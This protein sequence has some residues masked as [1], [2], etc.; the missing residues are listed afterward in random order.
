MPAI[1]V[2]KTDTFEILRQ[3]VNE[4]GSGLFN[5]SAGGSDLSAGNIKLGDG[6]RTAPSLSFTSDNSL[7]IYKPSNNTF[8]FVSGAKKVADFSNTGIYSFKDL[9]IRQTTLNTAGISVLNDGTN[10]DAGSYADIPLVGGTG[11]GATASIVVTEFDGNIIDPGSNYV[12]GSYSDIPLVGG[13]GSG[14]TASF[15]VEG[16]EGFISNTGTGYVPGTYLNVP[17]TGGSGSG[18]IADIIITGQTNLLGTITN[19]GSGYTEGVYTSVQVLNKPIQTFVVTTTS[20]PGTPPPNNVYVIDGVTQKQLTL[21]KG[22]TYRFDI[23]DSS[24]TGH[25]LIFQTSLGSFLS[26]SNYAAVTKGIAGQP[27][28]FVDLIIKPSAA[29]ETI[30][31]NCQVHDGMG[32]NISITTGT[33]GFYG[34]NASATITVNS[35]GNISDVEITSA[36]SGYKQNDIIQVYNINIGGTGSGFEFTLSAPSYTGEVTSVQIQGNGNNYVKNDVL[37]SS[38]SNLGGSGS[39]FAFTIDNDPNIVSDLSFTSKGSGYQIEDVLELPKT[40]SNVQTQLKSQ[41]SNL[42]TTLSTSSAVV[43]VSSTTGILPGMLVSQNIQGDVGL[44]SVGTT[45]LSVDSSTQLTLSANPTTSGS[46]TL[47]FTS[48]GVLTEISV[49][50]VQGIFVGSLVSKTAGTGILSSNTTVS[51]INSV[52]NTITLSQQPQ[53]AGTATLSFVPPFGDPPNDFQYEIT[54]LGQIESFTIESGGNGYSL[55]DTLSVNASDLTQPISYSV[56]NKEVIEITFVGTVSSTTFSVGD[57]LKKKDGEVISTTQVSAP[58]VSQTVISN[59][60]TT[61]SNSSPVITV[62][63]TTGI[64]AGM[65]VSQNFQTDTGVLSGGTTVLS[66]DSSTQLTLSVTPFTSGSATLTFSSDETGTYTNVSSTTSGN[67]SGATFDVE[68]N[69]SGNIT[70]ITVNSPGYFYTVGDI[71]TISGTSVGGVSPDNDIELEVSIVSTYQNLEIYSIQTSSGNISSILLDFDNINSGDLLIEPLLI[72]TEY[73]INTVSNLQY[74][75][76]ID[77]GSGPELTPNLTL[78]V[79]NTYNFDISDSSNSSHVFSLSKYRDGIWGPSLIENISTTLLTTS[80]QITV[81]NSTGILV[82]MAVTVSSGTG[83]LVTG[84]TVQSINGNTITLSSAPLSAGAVTLTFRGVEYTNGVTRSGTSLTIKVT[85]D[86]PNLYYYC[87]IQNSSHTNEGGKDNEEALITIDSNNPKIF[88]SGFSLSVAELQ[89]ADVITGDIETGE[90]T[91]TKFIGDEATLTTASVTG[92]L[93]SP[94]IT[95]N[96]ITATTITSS[97]SLG[98]TGTSINVTGNFNI[99]SNVQVASSTGNITTAGVLRTNNSLN[100]NDVLTITNNNI[101]TATGNNI[102]LSP[103]TGRVAKIAA[104]TALIIPVG[105]SAQRPTSGVIENGGIR[106]N[107]DTNQYEGYSATTSSWSSLGGV[108][109]LDGNTYIAA[110]AFTGAND[111]ILY[112]FNDSNNTLKLGTSYL[113]FTTVKKIRSLNTSLPSYTEWASNTPVTLGSYVKYRNNIYLVTASGA[114]GSSGN[115]PTHTTGSQPNGTATLEWYSSAVSPLTFEEIEELRVGPLGNLPLVINSDLRLA[116]NVIS[117]DISDIVIRPNSGKKVTVD[118]SSSLVIPSGDSNSRGVPLQGSIRYNTTITQFEGYNGSNWT[119]LGGVK[120]VDGNTYIIPETAPG[121]NENILYFYNDGNNTLR[122]STS[123]LD[124]R[125]ISKITSQSDSLDLDVST[126]S[127]NNFAASITTSGTSTYLS[128]AQTNLDFG[129][130]VGITNN[131]LL[132][133]NTSGDF[134][135]NKGFGTSNIV[136]IKV[137]DN[138]LKDFELDD[139]KISTADISL[140]K[141]TTNTGSNVVYSPAT[142]CAAKIIVSAH[143]TTTNDKEVIEFTVTDK[144]SDIFNTE[145]GNIRTNGAI[146]NPSFDFD[147]SSNVRLNVALDSTVSSGNIVNI[148]VVKTIIKK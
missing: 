95:S 36:G 141:G 18:A 111:N 62:S 20:N 126:L 114:T 21:I 101:A 50:S 47:T 68:R 108:R 23:S 16:I 34:T 139:T 123:A 146:I 13:S 82:G 64:T 8:G 28:S 81:S 145:I 53:Q 118:A 124:F 44:L 83:S 7:G 76:F 40:I 6:T 91:A 143:N 42:S 5:I 55:L 2:A 71:I 29:T 147:A 77:T 46:A 112:F 135:V 35:T 54:N 57:V 84:T 127:L 132:R 80:N 15:T 52:T 144:G 107:T 121:A 59:I 38:S 94:T 33:A 93:T 100:I 37:T 74:R 43:T 148:T 3:K 19:S 102:L 130:S 69:S 133:L 10:Y 78:F 1:Q 17:L 65:F 45:V 131:Y 48:S 136:P 120:D 86:T 26:Q 98:L 117:T 105:S 129:L 63:S 104:T 137:L 58:S 79:G 24:N 103:P 113:D 4:I 39:G 73:E 96:A 66:V 31:Y 72:N 138:E 88:G 99:G 115:E 142:A 134:I 32:A 70:S 92:T 89:S 9:V 125:S 49:S 87:G 25:P 90:F 27:G 75:Y 106:F 22:N 109:D 61:L 51:S 67:G 56:I 30:K 116:D 85:E 12:E 110:E 119:S 128:T 14:S 41:V 122:V 140:T 11:D 60:S 97:G